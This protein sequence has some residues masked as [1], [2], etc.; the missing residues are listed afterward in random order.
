MAGRSPEHSNHGEIQ[1]RSEEQVHQELW[2]ILKDQPRIT[3]G[4]IPDGNRR[5]ASSK[6]GV[7]APVAHKLGHNKGTEKV[8]GI[9]R[10]FREELP[11]MNLM[12]WGFSI[13]N[14]SRPPNELEEL[15][16]LLNDTVELMT[17]EAMEFDGRIIH[18]GRK[19]PLCDYGG[20]AL[21]PGLP[22]PLKET[23]IK[24]EKL[25]RN[26]TGPIIA[27]AINYAGWDELDRIRER[28]ER[29]MRNGEL[30]R[31]TLFTPELWLRYGD[32]AGTLGELICVIRTSGEHR[33]SKFG[34]RIGDSSSS[35]FRVIDK[36]LPEVK[37]IDVEA[38]ILDSLK[39]EKR[40]G[41]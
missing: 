24:A 34:W 19:D 4:L 2:E 13:D 28:Y 17:K 8:I 16:S 14:W 38:L 18:M 10:H 20:K 39:A 33:L 29:A 5:W 22:D 12:P 7:L 6:F 41:K 30:P 3:V 37:T 25:T 40:H 26:N 27:P 23:L 21:I 11:P 35:E 32:D 9:V 36:H 31:D 1:E 15:F